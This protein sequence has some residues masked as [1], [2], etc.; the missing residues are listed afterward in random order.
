MCSNSGFWRT[1]LDLHLLVR[2]CLGGILLAAGAAKLTDR[3][4]F[5]RAVLDFGV[6]PAPLGRLYGWCLLHGC[7]VE[8]ALHLELHVPRTSLS[9]EDGPS[10]FPSAP[11][12]PD[13][14][15][16]RHPA[17]KGSMSPNRIASPLILMRTSEGGCRRTVAY[18]ASLRAFRRLSSSSVHT[19]PSS[20]S[21]QAKRPPGT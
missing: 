10:T 2:L 17:L 8:C 20:L 19:W 3:A 12:E 18:D 5:V 11:S 14:P 9:R 15:V 16:S 1:E 7:F 13:V 6:L 21:T 4:G